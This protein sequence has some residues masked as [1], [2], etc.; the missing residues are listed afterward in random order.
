MYGANQVRGLCVIKF[1]TELAPGVGFGAAGFFHALAEFK[2]DDI[3][4]SGR[5]AGGGVFYCAG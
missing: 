2:E 3:V 4:S 5:L 1:E